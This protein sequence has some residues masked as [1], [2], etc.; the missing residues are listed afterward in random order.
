VSIES[1]MQNVTEKIKE[2]W[3]HLADKA[4][5]LAGALTGSSRRKRLAE[6]LRRSEDQYY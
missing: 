1:I 4:T 5:K 6:L 3:T 2:S